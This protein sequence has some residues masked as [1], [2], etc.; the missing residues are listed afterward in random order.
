MEYLTLQVR[1][2]DPVAVN[3]SDSPHPCCD[4]IKQGRRTKSASP[5]NENPSS[6]KLFLAFFA[7]T[8]KHEMPG[9]TLLLIG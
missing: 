8:L 7:D 3:D 4:Q 9:I 6:N 1:K 5:Y 2:L